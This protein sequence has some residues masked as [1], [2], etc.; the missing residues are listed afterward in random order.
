MRKFLKP[1]KSNGNNL[2]RKQAKVNL[3]W[4][5]AKK[6]EFLLKRIKKKKKIEEKSVHK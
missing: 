1:S 3:K 2:E 5:E 4:F 6:K